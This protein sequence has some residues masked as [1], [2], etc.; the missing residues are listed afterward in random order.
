M[1]NYLKTIKEMG[2]DLWRLI[3]INGGVKLTT[4]TSFVLKEL[5]EYERTGVTVLSCGTCLE[6]FGLTTQKAV[7]A[8]TNMLDIVTATQLADNVI[9]IG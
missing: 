5:Q 3:F 1:V 2:S 4:E 9:T 6:H 7:G 8:A